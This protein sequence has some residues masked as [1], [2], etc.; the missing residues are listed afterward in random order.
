MDPQP[1][2]HVLLGDLKDLFSSNKQDDDQKQSFP[3][4]IK[5]FTWDQNMYQEKENYL[6]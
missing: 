5:V 1:L 6:W 4:A 2:K 3:L